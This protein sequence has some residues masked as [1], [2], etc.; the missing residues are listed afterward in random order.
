MLRFSRT[1]ILRIAG[2]I[3]FGVGAF[4]VYKGLLFL[5]VERFS[6]E[7]HVD[8]TSRM[9]VLARSWGLDTVFFTLVMVS[10]VVGT[11]KGRMVLVRSINRM[12]KYLFS[13]KAPI[14]FYRMFPPA[15]WIIMIV[16]MGLGMLMNVLHVVLWLRGSID[17]AVGTALIQGAFQYF[18]RAKF[19]KARSA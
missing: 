18:Q 8:D 19:A 5:G 11:V 4:L 16:M 17:V 10:F 2:I 13:L 7:F 3:W 6:W 15:M 14:V 12:E 1:A 9:A